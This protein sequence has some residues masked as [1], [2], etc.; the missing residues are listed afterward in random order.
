MARGRGN[1]VAVNEYRVSV[2]QD[3]E[4]SRWLNNNVNVLNTPQTIYT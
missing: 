3:E 4:F 2:L 1:R